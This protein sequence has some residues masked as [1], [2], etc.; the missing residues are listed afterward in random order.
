[1]QSLRAEILE[2]LAGFN[3]VSCGE[4][5]NDNTEERF[6][7]WGLCGSLTLH[8]AKACQDLCSLVEPNAKR[9]RERETISIQFVVVLYHNET[10][11]RECWGYSSLELHG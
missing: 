3:L 5:D 8:F 11:A 10:E 4:L 2:L 6:E 7:V 1:M 9:V